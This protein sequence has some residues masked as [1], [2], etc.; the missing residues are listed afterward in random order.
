MPQFCKRKTVFQKIA[1]ERHRIYMEN[2][3]SIKKEIE[4]LRKQVNHHARLY[5]IYDAPEISDYEYDM[6]YSRLVKLES[7]NPDVCE[8]HHA[9]AAV[10]GAV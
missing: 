9:A 10:R 1:H 6:M 8:P 4:N 5:Y 2:K 3:D 7:E